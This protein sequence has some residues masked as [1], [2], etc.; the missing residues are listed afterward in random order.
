MVNHGFSSTAVTVSVGTDYP[1]EA[2]GDCISVYGDSAHLTPTVELLAAQG[3]ATIGLAPYVRW[4]GKMACDNS[5]SY[6]GREAARV[7]PHAQRRA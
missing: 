3:A 5:T 7:G 4:D 1:G 6:C 2:A